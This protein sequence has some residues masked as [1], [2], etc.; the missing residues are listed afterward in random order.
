MKPQFRFGDYLLDTERNKVLKDGKMIGLSPKA[1]ELLAVLI[2]NRGRVV[3]RDELMDRL[4][5]DVHV[6]D[7]NINFQISCL[8]KA[9]KQNGTL[10]SQYIRTLPKKGYS[11]VA[12]VEEIGIEPVA[13]LSSASFSFLP[14]P[15]WALVGVLL[16]V[17]G[18]ALLTVAVSQWQRSDERGIAVA[19]DDFSR[20]EAEGL[21]LKALR[22]WE[23]RD[24]SEQDPSELLR[25]AIERDPSMADARVLLA[26]TYAFDATPARVETALADA[27]AIAG[28]TGSIVATEAF[29]RMFHY[30]DWQGAEERFSRAIQL[31]P[32]EPKARHWYGVFLALN[33]DLKT[34]KR[35]LEIAAE[36]KPESLII[37]SDRAQ[38]D[39]FEGNL[40]E[41]ARRLEAVLT[42]EPRFSMARRYLAEIRESQGLETEA[43]E[44]RMS[45][46]LR[47]SESIA[48][49]RETFLRSGLRG[50]LLE[51]ADPSRCDSNPYG[52]AA[53]FAKLDDRDRALEF[54]RIALDKRSFEL[55]FAAV[56]PIF[57]NL[58]GD[59]SFTSVISQIK[60]GG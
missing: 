2:E 15:N 49:K 39:Y 46:A 55:P 26:D 45:S 7:G 12:E 59:P 57:I 36:L 34:A 28:E 48:Q 41:A 40:D 11:F 51:S 23:S 14:R 20:R 42:I 29:V 22:V 5:G 58:R 60:L 21:Y 53:T 24:F 37:A 54:L 35:Q 13:K 10:E 6:E 19:S 25:Q 33:G 17:I 52:C 3:T 27:R 4:W 9:L 8:R 16:I 32:R 50:L 18:G 44:H 30:W 43:F 56:D 38:I 31:D 1:V 47:D